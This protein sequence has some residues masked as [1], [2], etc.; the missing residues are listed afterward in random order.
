VVLTKTLRTS[1]RTA[2]E[3][4]RLMR[5]PSLRGDSGRR[6]LV[7]NRVYTAFLVRPEFV[8]KADALGVFGLHPL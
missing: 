6:S 3:S 8:R 4:M 1:L 2:L 7:F 5:P